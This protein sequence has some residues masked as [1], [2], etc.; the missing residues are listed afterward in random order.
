MK[1][2]LALF[3]LVLL[4]SACSTTCDNCYYGREEAYTVSQPVEVIYR[5]TTYR[6]VYEP[7]TYR[8]VTLERRPYKGKVD[9]YR[10]NH[11]NYCK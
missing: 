6:T 1:K 8:E 9:C 4:L 3:S 7:K 5:N 2:L 11:K 10:S